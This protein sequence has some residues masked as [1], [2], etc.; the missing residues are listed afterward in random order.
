MSGMTKIVVGTDEVFVRDWVDGKV[1]MSTSNEDI[2]EGFLTIKR[3]FPWA[4][5]FLTEPDETDEADMDGTVHAV[6][7]P[8]AVE[9]RVDLKERC[10]SF[11]ILEDVDDE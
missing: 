8:S 5:E 4:I 3:E 11:I 6:V 7:D 10:I 1:V 9:I 2:K